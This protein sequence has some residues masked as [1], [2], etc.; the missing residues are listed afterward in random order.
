MDSDKENEQQR[1]GSDAE[2]EQDVN[3][4]L[5]PMADDD[6]DGAGESPENSQ[7][8]EARVG[9]ELKVAKRKFE[10]VDKWELEFEEVTASSSSPWDAR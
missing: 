2:E 1:S 10:V 4:S 8:L 5:G 6:E 7:E 3:D 9:K